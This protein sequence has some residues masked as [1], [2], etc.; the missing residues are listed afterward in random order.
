MSPSGHEAD[1]DV[2]GETDY[3]TPLLFLA[4]WC[5]KRGGAI[6]TSCLMPN[7]GHLVAVPEREERLAG[8]TDWAAFLARNER[9]ASDDDVR[10]HGRTG[11]RWETNGFE[12]V[13]PG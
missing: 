4:T 11:C 5:Q 3:D 9:S 7:P 6:W 8:V 12:T 1:A 13:L 10:K 2:F